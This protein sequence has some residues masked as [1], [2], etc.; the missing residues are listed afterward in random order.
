MQVSVF[1]IQ[2]IMN[3]LLIFLTLDVAPSFLQLSV[4]IWRGW[5]INVLNFSYYSMEFI[6]KI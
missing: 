6:T 2:G 1:L 4:N 3:L 5:R